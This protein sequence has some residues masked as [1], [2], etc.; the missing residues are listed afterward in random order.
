M[1]QGPQAQRLNVAQPIQGGA[2][3]PQGPQA[4]RLNAAAAGN[5]AQPSQGSMMNSSSGGN[6]NR[7]LLNSSSGGNNNR[8][9]SSG[10]SNRS[11]SSGNNNRSSSGGNNNRSSNMIIILGSGTDDWGDSTKQAISTFKKFTDPL[12]WVSQ[13]QNG[14]VTVPRKKSDCEVVFTATNSIPFSK[15]NIEPYYILLGTNHT[16][17][18]ENEAH[19]FF[20]ERVNSFN[21]K[22]NAYRTKARQT[23]SK[24]NSFCKWA[25]SFNDIIKPCLDNGY[26]FI[27]KD[28]ISLKTC[29]MELIITKVIKVLKC[30]Y[31][32][33]QE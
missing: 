19:T 12:F 4:Q 8:S 6:S 2:I 17:L 15:Y 10:N 32:H 28:G 33:A 9:S 27:H 21:T 18:K 23:I 16:C 7:L 13:T 20:R 25:E 29:T 5:V 14:A 3:M 24:Y 30:Q 26:I 22:Y 31:E 1:P 11:S